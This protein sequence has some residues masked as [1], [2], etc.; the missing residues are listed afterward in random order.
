[1]VIITNL[2][3]FSNFLP[4]DAKQK[5]KQK[6]IMYEPKYKKT[7][8]TT[9]SVMISKLTPKTRERHMMMLVFNF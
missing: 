2:V 4:T 6:L 5:Q 9:I 7:P 8:E 1:M 3:S